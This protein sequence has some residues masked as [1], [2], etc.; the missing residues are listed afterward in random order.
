M[1]KISDMNI[2]EL[3]QLTDDAA[4]EISKAFYNMEISPLSGIE[5]EIKKDKK[6]WKK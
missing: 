1:K 3:K 6:K 5:I 2:E 4:I